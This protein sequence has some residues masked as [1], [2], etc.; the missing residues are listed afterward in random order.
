MHDVASSPLLRALVKSEEKG[1]EGETRKER[2][3]FVNPDQ[4]LRDS[5][6]TSIPLIIQHHLMTCI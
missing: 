3:L 1:E 4:V 6:A 2:V 5:I